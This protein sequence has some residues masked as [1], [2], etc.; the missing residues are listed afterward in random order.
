[1]LWHILSPPGIVSLHTGLEGEDLQ[2]EL[3]EH[4]TKKDEMLYY[5]KK[6]IIKSLNSGIKYY[7]KQQQKVSICSNTSLGL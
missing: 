4:L 1:M 3:E 2:L 5:K 6:I 7:F